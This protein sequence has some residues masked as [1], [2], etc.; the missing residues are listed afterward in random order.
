MADKNKTIRIIFLV[1]ALIYMGLIFYLSS[2]SQPGIA[3]V[4]LINMENFYGHVLEYGVLALFLFFALK[5]DN[6][7]GK[8]MVL[9]LVCAILIATMYG[10]TD[11]MHQFYVAGRVCDAFD[12]AADCV[13]GILGALMSFAIIC[14][15]R[16][17]RK[18]R[19]K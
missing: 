8:M 12:V 11:E 2:M 18:G 3:R 16:G 1:L 15:K 5:G 4:K 19:G 6:K 9:Y 17:E 13:G 14:R 7:D 10:I